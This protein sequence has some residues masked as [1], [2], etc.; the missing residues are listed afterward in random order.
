M[1]KISGGFEP[2]TLQLQEG[3]KGKMFLKNGANK[4]V[5]IYS[6]TE[7]TDRNGMER[8]YPKFCLGSPSVQ[9]LPSLREPVSLGKGSNFFSKFQAG[10]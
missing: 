7:L 8:T 3:G 4:T 5:W 2:D 6:R 1:I 10:P 9:H